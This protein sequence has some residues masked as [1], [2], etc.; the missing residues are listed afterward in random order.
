MV[1]GRM[2]FVAG[3]TAGIPGSPELQEL[4]IRAQTAACLERIEHLL[5]S[6]G[7]CLDDVV[8]TTCFV[9]D[10]DTFPDFDDEY[11]RVFSEPPPARSTVQVGRFPPGVLVE[12]EAIA[13]LP[14]GE[15]SD[16]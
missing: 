5:K 16:G 15:S 8:K 12:I 7:A 14:G 1:S 6:E 2:M 9:A 13:V 11:R 10:I 4:D 3:Q